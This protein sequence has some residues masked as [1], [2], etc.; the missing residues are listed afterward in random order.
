MRKFLAFLKANLK[1]ILEYRGNFLIYIISNSTIPLVSLA[2]WLAIQQSNPQLEFN[3][4]EL[5]WYFLLVVLME[6]INSAWH[7]YYINQ[8]IVSGNFSKYLIKPFSILQDIFGAN[9][10]DKIYKIPITLLLISI[11]AIFLNATQVSKINLD[12]I[13]FLLFLISV[14]MA[15]IIKVLLEVTIGLLAFWVHDNSFIR[16]FLSLIADFFSGAIIP[17]SFLPSALLTVA[18]VLPYRYTVAFPIEIIL[19]KLSVQEI[20]LGFLIQISW[21]VILYITYRKVF[22]KGVKSYQGYGS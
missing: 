17:L 7:G 22:S 8:D 11:L 21:V 1:S 2:V 13:I 3:R 20:I 4:T 5:I 15:I 9:L 10:A 14:T 16:N 19:N 12:P 6:N 18:I